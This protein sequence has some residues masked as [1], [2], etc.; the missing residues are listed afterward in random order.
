MLQLCDHVLCFWFVMLWRNQKRVEI[1]KREKL[2]FSCF[3]YDKISVCTSKCRCRRCNRKHHMSIFNNQ[4]DGEG[5]KKNSESANNATILTTITPA[6]PDD[7]VCLLETVNATG[8]NKGIQTQAYILFDEWSQRLFL[9]QPLA[10]NLSIWPYQKETIHFSSFRTTSLLAL[11]Q[12]H[13]LLSFTSLP[14]CLW[15]LLV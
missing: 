6:M 15:W 1:I 4:P 13:I 3:G 9:S 8:V 14:D 5:E 11:S 2:C 10:D 12:K 7:T